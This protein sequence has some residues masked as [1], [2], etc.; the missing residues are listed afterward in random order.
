MSSIYMDGKSFNII[1]YENEI[2]PFIKREIN[3]S[4]VEFKGG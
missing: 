2:N 1:M 3:S 4:I